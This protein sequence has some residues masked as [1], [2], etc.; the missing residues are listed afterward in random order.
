MACLGSLGCEAESLPDVLAFDEDLAGAKGHDPADTLDPSE[1]VDRSG[2][3]G[4]GPPGISALIDTNC[5]E[6]GRR[7]RE[8]EM[9]SHL[10]NGLVYDARVSIQSS[11]FD[12]MPAIAIADAREIGFRPVQVDMKPRYDF[13]QLGWPAH[14]GTVTLIAD[15]DANHLVE[16]VI[17]LDI[18]DFEDDYNDRSQA[19]WRPLA[20]TPY[21]VDEPFGGS[22]GWV[23]QQRFAAI[24]VK[25]GLPLDWDAEWD[26]TLSQLDSRLQAYEMTGE[27][28]ISIEG[29]IRGTEDEQLDFERRYAV[30]AAR[31][32]D[33]TIFGDWTYS[34][35]L[36][37]WELQDDLDDKEQEGFVPYYVSTVHLDPSTPNAFEFNVLYTEA[38]SPGLLDVDVVQYYSET[39]LQAANDGRRSQ[40]YHLV[41]VARHPGSGFQRSFTAIWHRYGWTE[42]VEGD[43]ATEA[44]D[45][46]DLEDLMEGLMETWGIPA[47]QLAV[48]EGNDLVISRAYTRA[49]VAYA[50]ITTATPMMAASITKP[51]TAVLALQSFT[52]A[53]L[54]TDLMSLVPDPSTGSKPSGM[55][56]QQALQHT[57][58]FTLSP[59]WEADVDE[60]YDR[61]PR[62]VWMRGTG[63]GTLEEA[64]VLEP[65]P[66]ASGWTIAHADLERDGTPE[67]LV[68]A[69]GMVRD[70]GEPNI[71]G[72]FHLLSYRDERLSVVAP[73]FIEA[74]TTRGRILLQD[75]DG[76]GFED[77]VRVTGGLSVRWGC[78]R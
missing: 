65:T 20:I 2:E 48:M 62:F 39:S 17:G 78:P 46:E 33:I 23:D 11:P 4:A 47:A 27:R 24:W 22:W 73:G 76:D 70:D 29:M 61:K 13:G 1:L 55:T 9:P 10:G 14:E 8:F 26:L 43:I 49:P 37:S 31:K 36:A 18:Y 54:P 6:P 12:P 74:G 3:L 52:T 7:M 38:P 64:A 25:D 58:G 5:D 56:L 75:M 53:A 42:T 69:G 35:G 45:L 60:L 28:P 32:E 41:S 16:T 30:V 77:F 44:G 51:L 66:G 68:L 34:L 71:E 72:A 21:Y 63:D 50:P 67:L 57:S 19:G 15:E 59:T 40:G